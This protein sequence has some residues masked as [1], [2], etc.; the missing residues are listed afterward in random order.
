MST[1]IRLAR[2]LALALVPALAA[3]CTRGEGGHPTAGQ[4]VWSGGQL[5]GHFVEVTRVDDLSVRG[6]GTIGPDGRFALERLVDGKTVPGLPPGEYQARLILTDEGD[7]QAKK[8]NVPARY[9]D[10]KTAGWRVTVPAPGDVTLTVAP[11]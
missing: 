3:G 2:A 8:P 7:G 11:K 5:G 9:L 6:F 4:V 1:D 10:Q